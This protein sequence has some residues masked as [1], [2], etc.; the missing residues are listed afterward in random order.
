M[1]EKV[2]EKEKLLDNITNTSAPRSL[3][4]M[5]SLVDLA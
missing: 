4:Q 2:R 5:L 1:L 3:A